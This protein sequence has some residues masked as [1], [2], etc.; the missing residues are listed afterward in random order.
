MAPFGDGDYH[1]LF[2]E[3]LFIV[4]LYGTDEDVVKFYRL[5]EHK[6]EPE[7][8]VEMAALLEEIKRKKLTKMNWYCCWRCQH[9]KICRINWYRG[10]RNIER[11]CCTYCQNYEECYKR[12]LNENKNKDKDSK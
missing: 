7:N 10:E 2:L 5:L 4:H 12:F 6:E 3:E 1:P 9:Y 8:I 11:H